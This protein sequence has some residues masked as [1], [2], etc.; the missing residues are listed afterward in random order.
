MLL[1]QK[2][3]L[4]H[5]LRAYVLDQQQV[6]DLPHIGLLSSG[7]TFQKVEQTWSHLMFLRTPLKDVPLTNF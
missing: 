1:S 6:S 3:L 2:K 5:A 7:M 4:L